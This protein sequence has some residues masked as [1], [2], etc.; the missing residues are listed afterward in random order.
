MSG[1]LMVKFAAV[2]ARCPACCWGQEQDGF[3]RWMS[4]VRR[5]KN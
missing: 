5:Y 1:F 3:Y 4:G 2:R